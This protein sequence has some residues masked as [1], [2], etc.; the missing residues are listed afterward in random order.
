MVHFAA[1]VGWDWGS[2]EHAIDVE[3]ADGHRWERMIPH[4]PGAMRELFDE[5]HQRYGGA[6]VAVAIEQCRGPVIYALFEC[7]FIHPIPVNPRALA[8]YRDS[9]RLSGACDDASD[10]AMIRELVQKH[11]D[12]YPVWVPD[13]ELTRALRT[14]VEWRRK[15]VEN[16]TALTQQLRDRLKEYFPLALEVMGE[17][18]SPMAAAFLRRWP[19]L[20]ALKKSRP[21]TIRDFY[22]AHGSRSKDTIARRLE[23]IRTAFPLTTNTAILHSCSFAALQLVAQIEAAQKSVA[24]YDLEIAK[25]WK[26]HP[27]AAIFQSLPGAGAVLA[28]RLAVAFGLIQ[29]RWRSARE[30][31]DYSGV[32]PVRQQSG[33]YVSVHARWAKPTFLYQTFHEFAEQSAYKPGW[34]REYYLEQK[35]LGKK[36]HTIFRALAYRWIRVIFACWRDQIP[37]DEA[38]YQDALR[39]AGSPLAHRLAA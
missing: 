2:R 30:L 14:F 27:Q 10:A 35:A 33:R 39:R 3:G 16:R 34:A 26:T 31:Q 20:E 12:R 7:E 37:Y 5:L 28:P 36:Q 9:L 38:T 17:L 32:S 24:S 11:P 25:L 6:P 8:R 18:D 13:D 29:D 4:R 15:T 1:Y 19:T 23:A 22:Y 21:E